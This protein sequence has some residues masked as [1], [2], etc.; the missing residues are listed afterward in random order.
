MLT[1]IHFTVLCIFFYFLSQTSLKVDEMG[2]IIIILICS[3]WRQFKIEN[4]FSS[5]K[6]ISR[7]RRVFFVLKVFLITFFV[8]LYK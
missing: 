8:Y 5:E 1:I 6:I 2:Q 3:T 4:S 7:V